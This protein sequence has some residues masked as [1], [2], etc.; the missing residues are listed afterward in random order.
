[1]VICEPL[2]RFAPAAGEEIVE[3]GGVESVEG[4]ASAMSPILTV[5]LHTVTALSFLVLGRRRA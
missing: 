4:A 1:M 3:V 5:V 2:G